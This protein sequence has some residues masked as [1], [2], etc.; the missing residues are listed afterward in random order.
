MVNT[1]GKLVLAVY[2]YIVRVHNKL[3]SKNAFCV[4]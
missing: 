2:A 4:Y 3:A 1:Y